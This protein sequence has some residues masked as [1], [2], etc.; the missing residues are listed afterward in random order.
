MKFKNV[1]MLTALSSGLLLQN[2]TRDNKVAT[3]AGGENNFEVECDR[4]ADLQVL[5]YQ[6]PGFELLSAQQ[7]ELAYYLY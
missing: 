3:N 4:F 5:R 1:M 6:I 2:C 7:K